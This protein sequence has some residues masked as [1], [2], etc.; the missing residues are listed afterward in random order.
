[1]DRKKTVNLKGGTKLKSETLARMRLLVQSEGNGKSISSRKM[2]TLSGTFNIVVGVDSM[3]HS[4]N[5]SGGAQP[6]QSG[7]LAVAV[8]EEAPCGCAAFKL[9]SAA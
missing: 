8:E 1:M 5:L 9:A 4:P 7:S 3:V 2:N 6:C